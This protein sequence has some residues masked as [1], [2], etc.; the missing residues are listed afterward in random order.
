MPGPY[1]PFSLPAQ[2]ATGRHV[3]WRTW[4]MAQQ[5]G[6]SIPLIKADMPPMEAVQDAFKEI[7]GNGRVTNFGRYLQQ[8]EGEVGDYLGTNACCLSSATAGLIMTL[9]ALEIPRG[10]RIVIPSSTFVATAQA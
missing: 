5:Q 3:F 9:Q 7:L 6:P 2:H 10:S 1:I 8:F 4:P